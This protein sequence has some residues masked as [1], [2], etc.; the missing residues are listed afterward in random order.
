MNW[1][2]WAPGGAALLHIIEEFVF[3]GGFAEW[4]RNYSPGIRSSITPRLLVI[5]NAL[6]LL[7][8]VAVGVAGPTPH[9]V[10]G[11]LTLAGL[12][13]SNAIFMR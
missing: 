7:A 11:W 3:P 8:G 1:L 2:F 13:V 5:L 10:A 6:L 12:L 9:G 4:Y